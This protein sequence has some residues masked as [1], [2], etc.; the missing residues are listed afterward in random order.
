MM[1]KT[2]PHPESRYLPRT[3]ILSVLFLCIGVCLA[4]VKPLEAQNAKSP[5]AIIAYYS[6]DGNDIR[7]YPLAK[8]THINYSF[9]H[10]N[11]HRMAVDSGDDSTALCRLVSLKKDYPGL[12]IILSLGGWGGCPTCS[13][14]FS[15]EAGRSEFAASVLSLLKRYGADGLDLDWEYPA[16]ESVPGHRYTTED[17]ANFTSL[18]RSLQQTLGNEYELSFAAG[19]FSEYLQNSVEWVK[20]MPLVTRVNLMTYDLVNGNSKAT[21]HLTPL[22][23]TPMQKESTDHAVMFLDSLGVDLRKVVIGMAFYGREFTGVS[24][25]N[26]GLYQK[27]KFSGYVTYRDLERRTGKGSG[28][29]RHWDFIARAPW[30][31]NPAT[32]TFITYDD[33]QSVNYKTTYARDHGLGGVMFW[34]LSDDKESG[35]LLD[36]IWEGSRK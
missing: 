32:G 12:K 18:I 19:G 2:D 22:Y 15:T 29:E 33:L 26:H 35:G 16:L 1:Q 23:S 3:G 4:A 17:K 6:G 30:A 9:L 36:M 13:Q 24:D 20:I 14:V 25:K 31:Y 10:L 8:L 27:G 7:N 21:G 11:G 34:E 5:F 28:Y